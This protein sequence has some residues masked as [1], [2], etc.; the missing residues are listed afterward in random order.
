MAAAWVVA[1]PVP[2]VAE[3]SETAQRKRRT[4]VRRWRLGDCSDTAWIV[5]ASARVPAAAGLLAPI[6]SAAA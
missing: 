2:A 3:A 6:T 4:A 5:S 1:A